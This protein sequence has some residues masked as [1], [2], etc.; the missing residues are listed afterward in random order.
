MLPI[1]VPARKTDCGSSFPAQ[2]I[3][4]FALWTSS[5][6]IRGLFSNLTH[7]YRSEQPE[8]P[9]P[10]DSGASLRSSLTAFAAVLTS[11]AVVERVAPFSPTRSR[12]VNP[13]GWE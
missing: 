9:D 8:S 2:I 6:L 1:P 4:D 13:R 12:L 10:F 7:E 3:K 11:S 5:G